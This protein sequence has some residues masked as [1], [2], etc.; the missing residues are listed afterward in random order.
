MSVFFVRQGVRKENSLS[1]LTDE[2]H[3]R[4]GACKKDLVD[5]F[6]EEN[7]LRMGCLRKKTPFKLSRI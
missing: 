6:N 4:S 7:R 3:E 5:L 2:Q 1:Y